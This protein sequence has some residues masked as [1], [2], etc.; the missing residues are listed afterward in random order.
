MLEEHLS[1]TD[2]FCKRQG[3]GD[4]ASLENIHSHAPHHLNLQLKRHGAPVVLT[5][6]PWTPAQHEAAMARGPHWS[7]TEHLEFLQSE[8]ADM[9]RKAIWMALP[10]HLV[11]HLK[12]L[13]ISNQLDGQRQIHLENQSSKRFSNHEST[14][15]T[16]LY[17]SISKS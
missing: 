4:F 10:Y 16:R 11:K 5:T 1:I 6:P 8:I 15:R 13:H 7:A 3:R 9:V 2:L 12:N 17:A 14:N